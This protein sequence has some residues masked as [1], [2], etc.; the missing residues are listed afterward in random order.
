MVFCEVQFLYP[1]LLWA[2]ALAVVPILIHLFNFR[3]PKKVVFSDIRFLKQIAIETNKQKQVKHWL[4]LLSRVCMLLALVFAF[5]QPYI[6]ATVQNETQSKF[7]SVYLDNSFSMSLNGQNAMLLEEAKNKARTIAEAYGNSVQYQLINNDFEP[8]QQLLLEKKE[9][10]EKINQT[11]ISA[12]S[13]SAKQIYHRQLAA[14][15]PNFNSNASL[16]WISDAQ[17]SQFEWNQLKQDSLFPIHFI[18]LTAELKNNVYIDTVWCDEPMLKTNRTFTVHV[19]IH[20]HSE[21]DLQ[22][23]ALYFIID[24]KK[25]NLKNFSCKANQTEKLTFTHVLKDTNWHQCAFNINDYPM[26]FDDQYFFVLKATAQ[27]PILQVSQSNPNPA[28]ANVFETDSTYHFIQTS[29]EKLTTQALFNQ[30]LLILDGIEQLSTGTEESV[31]KYINE[32]GIVLFIPSMDQPVLSQ[33]F[34]QKLGFSLGLQQNISAEISEIQTKDELFKQVFT[35]LNQQTLYPKTS[36]Y[37]PIQ[38][39]PTITYQQVLGLNNGQAYAVKKKL[40]KGQFILMA[41]HLRSPQDEF[42]KHAFFVPFMLN[43][44]FLQKSKQILAY[45]IQQINDI[46]VNVYAEDNTFTLKRLS[47]NWLC[48]A[49]NKAGKYRVELPQ[50]LHQPGF[51]QIYKDNQLIT[52]FA[53]N[54]NRLESDLMFSNSEKLEKVGVIIESE[55]SDALKNQ[56]QLV[57]NGNPLWRYFLLAAILFYLLE[58]LLLKY[59]QNIKSIFLK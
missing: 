5:A 51:Y 7:V 8:E 46:P 34:L 38:F 14:F 27:I 56:I 11:K 4:I 45:Q 52:Q 20:N 15:Q 25:V 50:N 29:P 40:G 54:N 28:F 36:T 58:I 18:P 10:L 33:A 3:R 57:Q 1:S 17:N 6:P 9:F 47:Q 2:S 22:N 35:Q 24:Q 37:Y 53:L 32:G 59:S 13:K 19:N 30:Q 12:F 39:N 48:T 55:N 43:M 23:Q 42:T 49:S 31:L 26:V 21:S 16:Y 41:T 44:P